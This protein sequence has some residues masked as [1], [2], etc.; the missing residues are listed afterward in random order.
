MADE[1]K[2]AKDGLAS[3]LSTISGLR[4]MDFPPDS[5]SEFPMALVLFESRDATQ[6]LGGSSFA[7]KIK[8][9]LLVSS[10]DTQQAYDALDQFMAPLGS[11]SIEAAVDGDN[12]WGRVFSPRLR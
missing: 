7:G 4:V 2:D 3:R 12:T 9:I 10:A 1:I 8:A 5:V 6:T 11:S